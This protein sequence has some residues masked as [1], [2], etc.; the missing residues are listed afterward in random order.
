MF[1]LRNRASARDVL[2]DL[3]LLYNLKNV[4]NIHGGVILIVKF[5]GVFHIFKIVQM[6]RNRKKRH[7][8]YQWI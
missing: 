4:K 7:I 6:V 8:F 1:F 5:L 3:A 2:N